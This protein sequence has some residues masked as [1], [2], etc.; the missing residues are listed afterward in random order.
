MNKNIAAALI[1]GIG[2]FTSSS[3][4]ADLFISA[5]ESVLKLDTNGITSTYVSGISGGSAGLAFD[6]SGTLYVKSV[7][8]TIY[9]VSAEG[10][11]S[12]FVQS[13]LL[14]GQGALAFDRLGNLYA[15]GGNNLNVLKIT[16]G[17]IVSVFAP[18]SLFTISAANMAGLAVDSLNNVYVSTWDDHTILKITPAGSS[19]LFYA[20]DSSIVTSGLAVDGQDNVYTATFGNKIVKVTPEGVASTLVEGNGLQGTYGLTIDEAGN[21]YGA[22]YP[23]QANNTVIKVTPEGSASVYAS[24]V[25]GNGGGLT[26][27]AAVPEPSTYTLLL[28]S[29]A[30]ALLWVRRLRS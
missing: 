2:V 16:P 25:G 13:P 14:S 22:N 26:Y 30:G 19:S 15:G 27:I 10:T 20:G 9:R 3:I 6:S 17:G 28:L 24:G 1:F 5:G 21:L 4:A 18:S 8:D 23:W 7:I 12:V 29:G 11:L